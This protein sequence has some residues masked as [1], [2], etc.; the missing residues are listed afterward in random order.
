MDGGKTYA[1]KGSFEIWCATHDSGLAK[2]Q[3]TVLLTTFTDGKSKVR[4]LV[5]F[6][7]KGLSIANKKLK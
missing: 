3:C 4:S 2:R 6:E 1:H 5:V 7:G